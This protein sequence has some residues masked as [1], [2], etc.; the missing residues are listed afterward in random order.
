MS[1][2]V[3]SEVCPRRSVIFLIVQYPLPWSFSSLRR[4][5]LEQKQSSVESTTQ[6]LMT[7][8]GKKRSFDDDDAPILGILWCMGGI[9]KCRVSDSSFSD[10][11]EGFEDEDEEDSGGPPPLKKVARTSATGLFIILCILSR[12]VF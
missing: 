6:K 4:T 7:V 3:A 1:V 2:D 8:N 5:S 10:N 11:E 12:N 9:H